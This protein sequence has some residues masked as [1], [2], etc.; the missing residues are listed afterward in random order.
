[1]L[2]QEDAGIFTS[3][4]LLRER[5][6]T[7]APSPP[8]VAESV[9]GARCPVASQ[10]AVLSVIPAHEAD[11]HHKAPIVFKGWIGSH[12]VCHSAATCITRRHSGACFCFWF[13]VSLP[14]TQSHSVLPLGLFDFNLGD[15]TKAPH[16]APTS[17]QSQIDLFEDNCGKVLMRQFLWGHMVC[18]VCLHGSFYL[19]GSALGS[20]CQSRHMAGI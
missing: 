15:F 14:A 12:S 4:R 16:S 3:T 10:W 17:A 1:M 18:F 20:V 19:S 9:L 7:N 11:S 8:S 6:L 13:L 2:T 5:K